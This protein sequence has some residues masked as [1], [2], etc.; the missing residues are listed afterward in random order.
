MV[1]FAAGLIPCPLT[2]FAMVLAILRG[3]P[4]AGIAF[5]VSMLIGIA[6]TLS[7][8]AAATVVARDRVA[9]FMERHGASMV[10]VARALDAIGGTL[11]IAIGIT[12][13]V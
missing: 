11:L 1:G 9:L 4:E 7:A 13:L 3:I 5:A 8:V 2:L 12:Q 10:R 6:L